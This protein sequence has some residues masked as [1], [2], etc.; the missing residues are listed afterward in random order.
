MHHTEIQS[1]LISSHFHLSFVA[2]HITAPEPNGFGAAKAMLNAVQDAGCSMNDV[3]YINT[4]ATSTPLGD[5]AEINAIAL[6]LNQSPTAEQHPPILVSSTKGAT[7]H[8]LGA[9]GALEAAL[10]VKSISENT[11]PHTRNLEDVSEDITKVLSRPCHSTRSIRLVK[12][13]P[14]KDGDFLPG[15]DLQVAMS[16]SFGFGGTNVSLLFG[17][18]K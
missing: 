8:L 6:A 11:I 9:A 2:F 5:V 1:S 12:D 13:K 16:N 4:H 18:V 15:R 17:K 3:D 10:T 7:G 14:I